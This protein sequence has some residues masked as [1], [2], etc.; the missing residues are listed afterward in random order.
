MTLY[1]YWRSSASWRVRIGL[2]LKGV[3][4]D[5]VPVDLRAGAQRRAEHDARNPLQ[6]VPVLEWTD[7]AGRHRLTQSMAILDWLEQHVPEPPLFPADPLRRARALE[8]AEIINTAVQPLQN[9]SVLA[10]VERL[11]ADRA[12]W[13]REH[14]AHGLRAVQAI[15]EPLRGRFLVGDAITVADLFLVPQ[16]Y[17][18]RRF[19][20][21][22]HAFAP[23][24]DI[25]ARLSEHP[26]FVAADAMNQPD[27]DR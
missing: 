23:L 8:L 16:M 12:R 10:A 3:D 15:S 26:A 4:Y 11:G 9:S 14:I 24:V 6:K 7:D 17:G 2:A 21:D 13:A 27:A 20:V 19:G 18:A 25:D 1:G 5:N 22:L